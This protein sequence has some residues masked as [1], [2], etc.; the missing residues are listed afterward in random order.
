MCGFYQA[1]KTQAQAIFPPQ[2]ARAPRTPRRMAGKGRK[3]QE[4]FTDGRFLVR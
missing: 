2:Q 4:T 3:A 1:R